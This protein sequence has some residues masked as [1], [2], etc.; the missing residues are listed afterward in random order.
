MRRGRRFVLPMVVASI[1][2]LVLGLSGPSQATTKKAARPTTG[3][4]PSAVNGS[5]SDTSYFMMNALDTLYNTSAGCNVIKPPEDPN[6]QALDNSCYPDTTGTITTENYRHDL[7]NGFAPVG[8]SNG[9]TELCTQGTTGVADISYARSSRAKR[10]TDCDGLTFVG[11]ALDAIPFEAFPNLPGSPVASMNNPDPL[12]A[13]KGLCLT[14]NQLTGIFVTCTITNWNQV[15][16]ANAPIEVWAAQDGSGT[17]GTFD[18]FI[19]GSSDS[20]LNDPSHEV[21]ENQNA[22]ILA[23]ADPQNAIF[24]YS[25]GDWNV[26]VKPHPDGSRLGAVD[27]VAPTNPNIQNGSFPFRRIIYNVY[28]NACTTGIN[29]TQATKDYVS[30][31][32][33]ICKVNNRHSIDPRTGQNYGQEVTQNIQKQG[34]VPHPVGPLPGGGSAKCEVATT[35]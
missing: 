16:G 18:G 26:E 12:C 31:T 13:G 24:Y 21:V 5:G 23:S 1:G 2:V 11:Y 29:A 33:W 3:E 28:C 35:P 30:E 15:G 22:S 17:R 10:V 25:L 34:F 20:C 19:G 7:V 27:G 9:I 32:G 4:T 8:S 6:P 14:T